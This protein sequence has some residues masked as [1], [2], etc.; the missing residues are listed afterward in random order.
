M[1]ICKWKVSSLVSLCR[2]H[3]LIWDTILGTCIKPCFPRAWLKY[4]K[5]MYNIIS[6]WWFN[7][8][9]VMKRNWYLIH[10]CTLLM[11]YIFSVGSNLVYIKGLNKNRHI[12]S[13]VRKQL[14]GNQPFWIGKYNYVSHKPQTCFYLLFVS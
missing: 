5:C 11:I 3:R 6:I 7:V 1:N 10:V 8:E 9:I 12:G 13:V 2:L 14:E 4:R